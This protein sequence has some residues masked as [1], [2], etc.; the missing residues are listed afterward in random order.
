[1]T[2]SL[3]AQVR[4]P[5]MPRGAPVSEPWALCTRK[6]AMEQVVGSINSR[7]DDSSKR[8]RI[9]SPSGLLENRRYLLC[10]LRIKSKI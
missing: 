7:G 1:M 9:Y 10:F 3:L 6:T 2:A 5:M 8:N 4:L